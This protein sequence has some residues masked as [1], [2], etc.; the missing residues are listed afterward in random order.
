MIK[1]QRGVNRKGKK[2]KGDYLQKEIFFKKIKKIMASGIFFLFI[3]Q[4]TLK[5]RA[6]FKC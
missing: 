3:F 2:E 6:I 4:E 5:K 1:Q